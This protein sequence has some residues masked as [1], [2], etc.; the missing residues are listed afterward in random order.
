MKKFILVLTLAHFASY[1]NPD[2]STDAPVKKGLIAK[3]KSWYN[4]SRLDESPTEL[5]TF[6][7]QPK[8]ALYYNYPVRLE[9]GNIQFLL[10]KRGHLGALEDGVTSPDGNG[11]RGPWTQMLGLSQL[12]HPKDDE[13]GLINDG[14][15]A[16]GVRFLLTA[17]DDSKD[18]DLNLG[19]SRESRWVN[20]SDIESGEAKDVAG[21][22]V[23]Y[24]K[25]DKGRAVVQELRKQL[26]QRGLAQSRMRDLGDIGLIDA[27]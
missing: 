4:K 15:S 10:S 27:D 8:M 6:K 11:P 16:L 23:R 17:S 13:M 7:A 2:A 22:F 26:I 24:L 14:K 20:A 25:S 18:R 12:W 3:I 1:S 9:D 21:H 19:D 5:G